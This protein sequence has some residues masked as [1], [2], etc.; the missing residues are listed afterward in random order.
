MHWRSWPT[1]T[2]YAVAVALPTEASA[3]EFWAFYSGQ[4]QRLASDSACPR[5]LQVAASPRS[6]ARIPPEPTTMAGG[7]SSP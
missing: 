4:R 7:A 3:Y 1:A 5:T 2:V 6:A